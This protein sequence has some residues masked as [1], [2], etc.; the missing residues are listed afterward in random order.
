LKPQKTRGQMKGGG[1]QKKSKTVADGKEEKK[2]RD[3]TE[4]GKL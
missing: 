3:R 1:A 2:L 4:N